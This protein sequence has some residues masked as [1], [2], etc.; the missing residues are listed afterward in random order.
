MRTTPVPSKKASVPNSVLAALPRP[1]YEAL[2]SGLEEVQLIFAEILYEPGKIIEHVYFPGNSLVS[3]L[4]LV[5]QHSA[6]EVGMV[7]RE[8]MVGMSLTLGSRVSPVRAL[9]Q[10]SGSAMRMKADRF[11]RE[12]K[13]GAAL[14]RG[15]Y[16]YL[17][18][19]MAQITQTAAC[20]RFHRIEGRLAR[21]LLMTS[22][23]VRSDKFELT[24][25]FLSHMLGVRRVGVTEAA[26]ALQK[27]KLIAYRR[28]HITILDHAGLEA[29]SCPCYA[30]VRDMNDAHH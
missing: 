15:L 27:Q 5:D 24:Q 26:S 14:Q 13:R 12:F 4:T 16:T 2:R 19:L 18:A 30:L 29:A 1:A 7:G 17:N 21:W 28:G 6:L 3:L 20:N 23:R 8:G 25:D 9:V 10:G 11:R 22:D